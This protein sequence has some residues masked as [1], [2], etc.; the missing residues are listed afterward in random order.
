MFQDILLEPEQE[1]LL[2]KLVEAYRNVLPEKRQKF[3]CP[4]AIGHTVV[5]HPG[6]PDQKMSAFLGDVEVLGNNGLLSISQHPEREDIRIFHILPLGF[7]YYEDLKSKAG[8]PFQHV[9]SPIL[10]YLS[11]ESFQRTFPTAYRKWSEAETLLWA[12]DSERQLSSIGHLCR[13]AMQEFASAL[14]S[15]YAP[16]TFNPDPAKTVARV[17][18]VL[19]HR[20]STLGSKEKA[21]LE[22][23]LSYWGTVVDLVQRQEHAGQKE[24]EPIVWEDGRR[25]VF[26]TAVVMFEI[27]SALA[28]GKQ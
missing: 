28:R 8:E 25:V 6:L 14:I 10:G 9:Q 15:R 22:A 17:K 19:E 1:E 21:F 5:Q 18:A 26:Q 27:A 11:S 7:R 16:P 4:H 3:S 24:G 2:V 23:L 13:E 12:I 20:A